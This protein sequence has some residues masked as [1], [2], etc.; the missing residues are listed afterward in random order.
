MSLRSF[1]TT[2]PSPPS[3][4]YF[5]AP[6]RPVP[7]TTSL[8]PSLRFVLATKWKS[9]W[10]HS[11]CKALQLFCSLDMSRGILPARSRSN[12]SAD[13]KSPSTNSMP[14]EGPD[15]G[16]EPCSANIESKSFSGTSVDGDSLM[17]GIADPAYPAGL[18]DPD[19]TLALG[20]LCMFWG[21][22][23]PACLVAG[24]MALLGLISSCR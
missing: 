13:E 17:V 1:P 14:C 23:G 2:P 9:A 20:G 22:C 6:E 3:T 24:G 18:F 21:P 12:I 19:C 5:V 7:Y 11:H 15:P 4:S 8:E 16:M 10:S